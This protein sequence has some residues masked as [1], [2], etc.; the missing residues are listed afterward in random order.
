[1]KKKQR[2]GT[3]QPS[4]KDAKLELWL[5]GEFLCR[6]VSSDKERTL[7]AGIRYTSQ[8]QSSVLEVT[9]GMEP[10]WLRTVLAIGDEVAIRLVDEGEPTDAVGNFVRPLNADGAS[11]VKF[12]R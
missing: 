4:H 3:Q 11:I 2:K 12:R 7:R 5:N 8:D 6:A 10:L 1:M 9:D